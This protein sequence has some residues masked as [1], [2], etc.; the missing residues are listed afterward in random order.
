MIMMIIAH[1]D[2][3]NIANNDDYGNQYGDDDNVDDADA[4]R[5]AAIAK[6]KGGGKGINSS[7]F[8]NCTATAF[9]IHFSITPLAAASAACPAFLLSIPY[10]IA[11]SN[12]DSLTCFSLSN[13]L[14]N[15]SDF[16]CNYI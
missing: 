9:C 4:A 6:L 12:T 7:A 1:G 5:A 10:L 16:L 15:L 14:F 8:S 3:S 2:A 11:L 13:N